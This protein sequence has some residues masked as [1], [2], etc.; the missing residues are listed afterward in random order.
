[1]KDAHKI[2]EKIPPRKGDIMIKIRNFLNEKLDLQLNLEKT[3]ITHA[4]N[5]RAKFLGYEIH[6]TPKS[7]R[8]VVKKEMLDKNGKVKII[9]VI[10]T[11]RPLFSVPV[12]KIIA[13]LKEAKYTK[14]P[15]HQRWGVGSCKRWKRRNKSWKT[16]TLYR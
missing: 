7:K 11:T 13:K 6:I 2:K 3:K 12:D 4:I 16:Y 9:K 1:M 14:D 10:N 5:D 15:P 8:P